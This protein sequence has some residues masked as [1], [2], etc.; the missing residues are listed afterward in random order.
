MSSSKK[1]ARPK[2]SLPPQADF[3]QTQRLLAEHFR[4]CWTPITT[5]GEGD[6]LASRFGGRAALQDGE[7]S[8]KCGACGEHMPLWLQ[9][10]LNTV[11][12]SAREEIPEELRCG[13]L[14]FFYCTDNDCE[15]QDFGAFPENMISRIILA[16]SL[17]PKLRGTAHDHAP[18]QIITWDAHQDLPDVGEA[19][20]LTGHALDYDGAEAFCAR[21]RDGS[22]TLP[23]QQD[24]LRGWP[25]WVQGEAYF[26]CELCG[27]PLSYVF[28][29]ASNDH[30]PFMFGDLGVGHLCYCPK[31]PQ[32]G[33]FY[34]SCS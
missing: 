10:N 15:S 33:S 3:D 13:V 4:A 14:Q 31:H 1:R 26:E 27:T 20:R 23:R 25:Y 11:P 8:P 34:W 5:P 19:S 18:L 28:Q 2:P 6:A 7:E 30:V 24:K 9:L 12:V 21:H 29:V 22:G 32:R 17:C 16:S